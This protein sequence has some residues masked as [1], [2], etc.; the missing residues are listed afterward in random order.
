[1]VAKVQP[2]RFLIQS[3]AVIVLSPSVVYAHHC[4]SLSDCWSTATASAAAAL[5][6]AFIAV[7]FALFQSI[8]GVPQDP[9]L[10]SPQ[11]ADQPIDD[12]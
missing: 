1:M 10:R 12:P 8:T 6:A 3:I 11:N 9:E 7:M 2:V 5:G 4:S